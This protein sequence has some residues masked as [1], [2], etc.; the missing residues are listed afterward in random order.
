MPPRMPD[1]SPPAIHVRD[2]H[3]DYRALR[4]LRVRE[5]DVRDGESIA[6][7]GFD[8]AAAE[9][10]VNLLTAA[11]VP[12]AGRIEI[13]G[14]PTVDIQDAET[15]LSWLDGFG[16][17]S[18]RQVLIDNMTVEENLTMPLTMALHDVD[19]AVRVKV[20]A[21]AEEVGLSSDQLRQ[22]VTALGTGARLRVRLGRALAPA[23]RILL[24]EHPN[25]SLEAAD[26]PR[27][28][29]EYARLVRRRGIASV[30]VTADSAFASAVAQRVLTLQPATGELKPLSAWR[31][32]FHHS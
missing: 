14:R 17:V 24:S 18:D 20:A 12:D 13:F 22:P 28:A 7:L 2:V 21:L 1:P 11:T 23:P 10:F 27:F 4:P 30:V 31:R 9:V 29:A 32:L 8:R 5:L 6:L 19:S 15:W 16:I 26:L 25:A 3:K